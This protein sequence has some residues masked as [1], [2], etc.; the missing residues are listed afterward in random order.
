MLSDD[1]LRQ[2]GEEGYL[3]VRG[4]VPEELLGEIDNEI[5]ALLVTDPPPED[6]VG[7]HFWF[8]P[9]ER[10]PAAD[11]AL[12]YSD[13]LRSAGEL[14]APYRLYHNLDHIHIAL[15]YPPAPSGQADRTSRP[16]ARGRSSPLLHNAGW[17]L[18]R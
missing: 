4:V 5:D 10:L 17:H 18:S 15:N 1:Q 3:V 16:S 8:L 13:A 7:K 12:R 6:T 14:V 11:A 2:F 9:P